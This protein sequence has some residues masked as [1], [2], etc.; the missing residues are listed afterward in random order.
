MN[1]TNEAVLH[2]LQTLYLCMLLLLHR[3][4][5]EDYQPSGH[6]E[7]VMSFSERQQEYL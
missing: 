3:K 2:R 6:S 7:C 4:L 1:Y 5:S